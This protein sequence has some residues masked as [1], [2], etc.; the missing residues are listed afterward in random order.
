MSK[1]NKTKQQQQKNTCKDKNSNAWQIQKWMLIAIHWMEHRVSNEA[2][3]ESTQ[4]VEGVC[5]PI[6]GTAILTNQ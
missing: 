2:A 3:R 6:G 1:Q 4:G 5:S